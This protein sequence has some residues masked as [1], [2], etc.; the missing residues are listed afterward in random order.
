MILGSYMVNSFLSFA[1]TNEFQISYFRIGPTETRV[2]FI[3]IN[4]YIILF[5]TSHFELLLPMVVGACLLGLVI[6]TYQI[7]KQLWDMDM[8]AKKK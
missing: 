1:A 8:K 4:T 6:N 2:V 7:Q 5:G 3:A